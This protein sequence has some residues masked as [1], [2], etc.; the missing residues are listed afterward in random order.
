M[1]VIS[2]P[3]ECRLQKWA[4]PISFCGY[5]HDEQCGGGGMARTPFSSPFLTAAINWN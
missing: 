5:G 2:L 4:L 3:R 1:Q